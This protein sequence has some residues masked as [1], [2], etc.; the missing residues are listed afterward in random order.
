MLHG[1]IRDPHF[2]TSA[3]LPANILLSSVNTTKSP[4]HSFRSSAFCFLS[5]LS[6]RNPPDPQPTLTAHTQHLVF[7]SRR[8]NYWTLIS[9]LCLSYVSLFTLPVSC[10]H[11]SGLYGI[12]DNIK[13]S[14][15]ETIAIFFPATKFR[16]FLP[17]SEI[18][19]DI[20]ILSHIISSINTHTFTPKYHLNVRVKRSFP[21][22]R[23]INTWHFISN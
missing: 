14:F 19:F 11:L 10:T 2:F 22:N 5:H 23:A 9:F 18:Y 4:A 7:R 16:P 6:V 1:L 17:L 21:E 15:S 12:G 3:T 8:M 13:F 20:E